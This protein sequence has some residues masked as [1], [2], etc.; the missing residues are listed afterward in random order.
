MSRHISALTGDVVQSGDGI[1]VNGIVLTS[2]TITAY[3]LGH[4]YNKIITACVNGQ[5]VGWGYAPSFIHF[6]GRRQKL[7]KIEEITYWGD[8]YREKHCRYHKMV[9]IAVG[10]LTSREFYSDRLTD[11]ENE[12]HLTFCRGSKLRKCISKHIKFRARMDKYGYII[13]ETCITK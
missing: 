8:C 2:D 4:K 13:K 6:V 9:L 1:D 5:Y 10:G 7:D 3:E 12:R 11:E